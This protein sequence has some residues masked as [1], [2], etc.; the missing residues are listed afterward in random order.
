MALVFLNDFL[1]H[2]GL[3]SQRPQA[4]KLQVKVRS[5]RLAPLGCMVLGC[6]VLMDMVLR[7][8]RG[9]RLSPRRPPSRPPQS[10]RFSANAR[11]TSP[12]WRA[13]LASPR[14]ASEAAL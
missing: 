9:G 10:T 13:G 4:Q 14:L 12:A 6:M 11:N 8:L 2:E 7:C 3:G 5:P 1:L